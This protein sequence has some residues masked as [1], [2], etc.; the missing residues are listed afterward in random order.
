MNMLEQC[1]ALASEIRLQH[2]CVQGTYC[3]GEE[4]WKILCCPGKPERPPLT[5]DGQPMYLDA[6]DVIIPVTQPEGNLQF[7]AEGEVVFEPQIG[8]RIRFALGS[9]V[10]EYIVVERNN[11]CWH[12][13][14]GNREIQVSVE[15]LRK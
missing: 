9:M 5:F 8:D 11:P 7:V 14:F 1:T 4:L 13:L 10:T 12:F 2:F 15:K 6:A 3:R